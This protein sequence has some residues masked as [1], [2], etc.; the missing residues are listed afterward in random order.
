MVSMVDRLAL[1]YVHALLCAVPYTSWPTASSA[2]FCEA[3][4][5]V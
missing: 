3:A 1:C 2:R 5:L 4:L